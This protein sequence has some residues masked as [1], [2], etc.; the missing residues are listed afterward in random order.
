LARKASKREPVHNRFA[1]SCANLSAWFA[2]LKAATMSDSKQLLITL[3]HGTWPHGIFPPYARFKQWVRNLILR[4]RQEMPP[5]WYENNS[6]FLARLRTEL[7][8]IPHKMTPLLWSGENSI[9]VRDATAHALAEHLSA[10]HAQYPQ[11]TQLVI[12]HS[13]GGNIA[14]CALHRLQQLDPPRQCADR[15]FVTLATPF[16]EVHQADF[17]RRPLY[18]RM[19]LM[20]LVICPLLGV[21]LGAALAMLSLSDHFGADSW[22]FAIAIFLLVTAMFLVGWWWIIRRAPARQVK[23]DRLRLATRLGK[24]APAQPL[25]VVRAIDD[26]ASLIL[27]LGALLNHITARLITYIFLLQFLLLPTF[28]LFADMKWVPWLGEATFGGAMLGAIASTIALFGILI[29]SRSVHGWELAASPLECQINTQSAPD[30][31]GLSKIVT[32]PPH[33]YARSLRHGIYEHTDCAEAISVWV[34]S[35]LRS[36]MPLARELGDPEQKSCAT[37]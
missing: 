3:V 8:D 24:L 16:V 36:M 31:I 27:A 6:S 20:I 9:F 13:H 26:E 14:L 4:E 10:E 33:T 29:L 19:A 23:L 5:Y 18:M 34:H 12:A 2:G 28:L 32:L 37:S 30:A 21:L 1:A 15:L 11:A 17:G 25:L 35:Q 7:G 22:G